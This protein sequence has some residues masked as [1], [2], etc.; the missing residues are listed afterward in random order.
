LQKPVILTTLISEIGK[1]LQELQV[2]SCIA[3]DSLLTEP[4]KKPHKIVYFNLI[5]K[6][7]A[8]FGI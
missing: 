1:E 8:E 2:M 4:P 3:G 6:S 5:D 7:L